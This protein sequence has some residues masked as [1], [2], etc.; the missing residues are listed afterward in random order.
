MTD[1]VTCEVQAIIA[2]LELAVEKCS[3]DRSIRSMYVFTDCQSAVDILTKQNNAYKNIV[4]LKVVWGC[5]GRLKELGVSLNLIW[6][7][8]HADIVGNELA[9]SAAKSGCSIQ[10]ESD[11]TEQISEQVLFG[12]VKERGIKRWQE[13][14]N[15]SESGTWTKLFLKNVGKKLQFPRDRDSGMSYVRSLLNNAA[16]ADNMSRMGLAESPNCSCGKGRETVEHLLLDCSL[17][18]GA[19]GKL[20]SEIGNIWMEKKASGGLNF[21]LQTILNPFSN[22]RLS[23]VDS[24]QIMN[25]VFSFFRGLSKKL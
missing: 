19:R 11:K 3:S 1:N 8:G 17:E 14:W 23:S 15:I 5:A 18:A 16:V 25:C 2:A 7:P 20:E 10:G 9:D 22:P 4:D 13:K 6:I 24:S 12:W 21:D